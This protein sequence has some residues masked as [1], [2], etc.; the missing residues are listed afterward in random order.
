[1][2][3]A[4]LCRYYRGGKGEGRRGGGKALGESGVGERGG[5]RKGGGFPSRF[6][7][8][9]CHLG[10]LVFRHPAPPAPPTPYIIHGAILYPLPPL[11]VVFNF[12]EL[13]TL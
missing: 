4:D 1:M 8:S 12:L 6:P 3:G 9:A 7:F 13:T 10:S 5:G 2:G 11:C